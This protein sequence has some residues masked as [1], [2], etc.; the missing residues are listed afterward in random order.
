MDMDTGLIH[1]WARDCMQASQGVCVIKRE[2]VLWS[3]QVLHSLRSVC[4]LEAHESEAGGL[5]ERPATQA[6]LR[7]AL[8]VSRVVVAY[9][10][11]A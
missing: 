1:A 4:V 7:A 8:Q 10:E 6:L 2:V 3:L 5:G 9:G 11:P